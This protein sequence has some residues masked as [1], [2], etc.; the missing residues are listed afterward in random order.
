M[1]QK[2]YKVTNTWREAISSERTTRCDNVNLKQECKV[3][4]FASRSRIKNI[5][6]LE[7]EPV[8]FESVPRFG[9]IYVE[10][11]IKITRFLPKKSSGAHEQLMIVE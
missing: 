3:V 10:G 4:P 1:F 7:R 5:L 8:R 6:K 11:Y 2:F 9:L